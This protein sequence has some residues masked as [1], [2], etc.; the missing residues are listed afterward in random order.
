MKHVFCLQASDLEPKMG[1]RHPEWQLVR[2]SS[3]VF[4][5]DN[6][7]AILKKY[8]IPRE[9]KLGIL[10]LTIRRGQNSFSI[11]FI[12]VSREE[13]G[14]YR[15]VS[16][17]QLSFDCCSFCGCNCRMQGEALRTKLFILLGSFFVF[18]SLLGIERQKHLKN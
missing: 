8:A 14:Y 6:N 9:N 16:D 13:N 7:S 1:R 17:G 2:S 4:G 11:A 5:W 18:K 12:F 10:K 3:N 15:F